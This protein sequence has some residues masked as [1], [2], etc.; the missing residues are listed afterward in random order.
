[1]RAI[2]VSPQS[3]EQLTSLRQLY[4]HTRDVRVRT[5]TQ[6]VLLAVEHAM[7]APKIAEIVRE[8]DGTVRAWLRRYEAEGTE[9][10]SDR[11]RPGG[12][13]KITPAFVE[14]LLAAVRKRPRGLGLPFSL[15]RCQRLADYLAEQAGLRVSH[16]TIR[17]QL[18]EYGVALSRPQ[19]KVS[20]PDAEYEVKKRRLKTQ[21]AA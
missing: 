16:E 21:G 10:L 20:S 14:E 18:A 13:S 15:W 5:R 19:H 9:G 6:I 11:P 7:T 1:M 12:P 17:R 2:R 4:R 3:D 8:N